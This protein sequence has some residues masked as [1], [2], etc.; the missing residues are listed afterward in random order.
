MKTVSLTVKTIVWVVLCCCWLSVSWA[1]ESSGEGVIANETKEQYR[2]EILGKKAPAQSDKEYVIGYR[3]ILYVE[4]Y[5]EGPMAIGPGNPA[6]APA[7]ME[8]MAPGGQDDAASRGAGAEVGTD[9]RVSLR[10]IGDVYAVGMTLTQFADYLKKL[11][12]TVYDDPNVIVTL[13]KSNSRQYTI[14]GQ[15][16]TPGVFPLDYPTVVVKAIAKAGG[17]TEWADNK[18][19]IIRQGNDQIVEKGQEKAQGKVEKFEFDYDDFLDG[20]NTDKN[21]LLEPGDVVVAH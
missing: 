10:H 1:A 6:A 4:V 11:Y 17:F 7:A 8:G 9:G 21:I 2:Q 14:M 19:S 13:L 3:D 18:V 12:G 15:V 5:G 20:K 16:R